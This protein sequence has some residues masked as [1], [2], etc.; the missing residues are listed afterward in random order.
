MGQEKGRTKGLHYSLYAIN[1]M[2]QGAEILRH[3][4]V[5][6]Y[7]Y[8]DNKGRGLELALDFI[9]PY[10]I[11]PATW[12]AAGYQQITTITQNDSMALYELAY[13][14]YK[15]P[16]YLD[17]INRWTRPLDEIR[18]MGINT[19]THANLFDLDSTP[20]P[21]VAPRITTQPLSQ[22]VDESATV[23]FSVTASGS[24]TLNFQWFRNG[25]ANIGSDKQQLYRRASVIRR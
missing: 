23:T 20:L 10:A 22:T 6:L 19:L 9:T 13:S 11:N 1:A 24:A 4:N 18:V 12:T 7:S 25:S 8:K 5:D 17:A 16:L 21:A 15:K 3:R 14:Q 2:I